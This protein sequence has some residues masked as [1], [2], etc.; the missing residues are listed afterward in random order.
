MSG[1]ILGFSLGS[2]NT[3]VVVQSP[4]DGTV[5]AHSTA[6]ALTFTVTRK[7]EGENDSY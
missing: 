3:V 1:T 4:R 5:V 2:G 6:C 7:N